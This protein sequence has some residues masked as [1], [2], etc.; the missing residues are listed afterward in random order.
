M[1]R[2]RVSVPASIANLGPGFDCLAAAIELTNAISF[3]TTPGGCDV[4]IEGE[5]EGR[6][7]LDAS[8]LVLRAA[9]LAFERAGEQLPGLRVR[10]V[11]RIPPKSG[12]G[13]SAAAIIAGLCAANAL[14]G[15][16]FSKLDLLRMACDLE[17]H[18]DNAAAAL[19]GGL[20]I[21]SAD[22]RE[23]LVR[24]IPIPP[25]TVVVVLPD[26]DLTTAAMRAAVPHQVSLHDAVFNLGRG[27]LTVEALRL[28][29]YELL[30]QA[31]VD[32]L[33]EPH[34]RAFIPNYD[35]VVAS[36][37]QAGAAAVVLSGAGPSLVAFSPQGHAAIAASM[38]E[39]FQ[40]VG[41]QSRSFLQQ[42]S[43]RG[44]QVERL[45]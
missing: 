9:A 29:D 31:M 14:L 26:L 38:L 21:I 7:P 20:S 32:H 8:N 6:L 15:E 25:M 12:L 11:N 17:G 24:Q 18:A 36:A 30:G 33:H 40:Q 37:R 45:A 42:I 16:I 19:F 3:E 41:I 35:K 5:G 39:A 13:S 43:S 2:L 28:G 4:S 44:V 1:T 23:I 27:M 22:S 10:G 34:R